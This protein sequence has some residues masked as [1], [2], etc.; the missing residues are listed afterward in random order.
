MRDGALHFTAIAAN[1]TSLKLV[2]LCK[3]DADSVRMP[4]AIGQVGLLY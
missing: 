3:E 2:A 4:A 1:F